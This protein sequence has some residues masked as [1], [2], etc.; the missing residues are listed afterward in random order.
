MNQALTRTLF[1][2]TYH[3]LYIA[4]AN[5]LNMEGLFRIFGHFYATEQ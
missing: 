3:Y 1:N 2:E 5:L 4:L